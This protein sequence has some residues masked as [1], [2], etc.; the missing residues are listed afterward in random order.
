MKKTVLLTSV[1]L[2]SVLLTSVL[3]T[4]VLLTSVLL[5]S[6]LSA[7]FNQIH[8]NVMEPCKKVLIIF[9]HHFLIPYDLK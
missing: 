6:V 1:L 8:V 5:T 4:S 7:K 2:T 3:L 9:S